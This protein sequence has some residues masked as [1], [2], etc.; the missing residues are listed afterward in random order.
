MLRDQLAGL[1][2]RL[3][4]LHD[5]EP[6]AVVCGERL[7]LAAEQLVQRDAR[8]ARERVVEH[9]VEHGERHLRQPLVAQVREALL[10]A[11]VHCRR[12]FEGDLASLDRG[13]QLLDQDRH[14][15]L[16]QRDEREAQGPPAHA[17]P[18]LQI[19]QQERC[20]REHPDARVERTAHRHDGRADAD[21]GDL[22]GAHEHL[23]ACARRATRRAAGGSS[24]ARRSRAPGPRSGRRG[25]CRSPAR[26]ARRAACR[27]SRSGR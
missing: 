19:D 9:H 2:R 10:A 5:A 15:L 24:R 8:L 21:A 16:R 26:R 20:A 6:A 18:G 11:V 12:V 25:I 14:Q 23:T 27:R 1:A 17:A 22:D 3:G 13:R 7:G 4:G